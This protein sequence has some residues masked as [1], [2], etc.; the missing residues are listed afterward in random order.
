MLPLC[1]FLA[2]AN[3][4]TI[5]LTVNA[6]I[7]VCYA[8]SH[9]FVCCTQIQAPENPHSPHGMLPSLNRGLLGVKQLSRS[10]SVMSCMP[11]AKVLRFQ[12]P[13][14]SQLGTGMC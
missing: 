5:C 11:F 9:H 4:H 6:K 14:S 7:L 3:F 12:V 2:K 1:C 10:L 8:G 13:C